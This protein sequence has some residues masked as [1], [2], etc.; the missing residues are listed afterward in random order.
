M[1]KP[2]RAGIGCSFRHV[3]LY[4]SSFSAALGCDW[5]IT[6]EYRALTVRLR[7]REEQLFVLPALKRSAD[8]QPL[9]EEI[10]SI[11]YRGFGAQTE[12][13]CRVSPRRLKLFPCGDKKGRCGAVLEAEE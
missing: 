4:W 9:G 12:M 10:F 11:F 6:A 3:V 7:T 8:L 1:L 5:I 2:V 13:D